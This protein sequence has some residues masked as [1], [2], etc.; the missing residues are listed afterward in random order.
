[1]KQRAPL[2]FVATSRDTVG[3]QLSSPSTALLI[4]AT[5]PHAPNDTTTLQMDDVIAANIK[6]ERVAGTTDDDDDD[7]D[8]SESA[9]LPL[10]GNPA[11]CPRCRK[12]APP[13]S[14]HCFVC[15]ACVVRQD[16]HNVW[17]NCCIGQT[18]YRLYF[19]GGAF[20]VAALVVGVNLAL[21]AI[22]HPFLVGS[23]FGVFVFLPDDCGEVYMQY[24]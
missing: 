19:V 23:F 14:Y 13:R 1:M 8:D 6:N 12:Y 21:T 3:G 22:C 2:D 24:E 4:D 9:A 18:S 11:V 20:G 10:S 5:D 17:L 7:E 15:N 16:H